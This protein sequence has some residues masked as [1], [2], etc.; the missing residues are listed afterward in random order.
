M[1]KSDKEL[2]VE[3]SIA[4]IN[5]NPRTTYKINNVQ[6]GVTQSLDIPSI[7]NVIKHYYKLLS[8]L[9]KGE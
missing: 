8:E 1:P 7:D 3:L 2:A 9:N 4:I 5:A 6:D